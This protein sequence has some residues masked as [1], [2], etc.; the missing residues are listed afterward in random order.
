[1]K[2]RL[3]L[4]AA[5]ATLL[6]VTASAEGFNFGVKGGISGNWMP[7]TFIDYGD[8][9]VPNFG[10]YGGITGALDISD[11]AFG[12]VEVLYSRKGISTRSDIQG[13]YS[14]NI[15]YIQVPVLFGMKMY[16]ERFSL[17]L[18]P[19]FNFCI[20]NK[21]KCDYPNFSSMGEPRKFNFGIAVQATFMVTDNLGVDVKADVGLTK[22]MQNAV[23]PTTG[24][25]DQGRN[26]GVL[27][28]LCYKFE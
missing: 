25:D 1:M 16:S 27:L 21:I 3:I 13:K 20:G 22:T 17:M 11:M 23:N 18:G 24:A 2:A 15:S 7:R 8:R 19:E 6:C 9:V 14:R 10:F 5:V 28:G 4:A 26:L 12:Q